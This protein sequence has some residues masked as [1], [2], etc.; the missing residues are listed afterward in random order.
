MN[1][2]V[3]KDKIEHY[4][5]VSR[6]AV[7]VIKQ[8]GFDEIREE[9]AKDFLNMAESYLS[10]AQH[11]FEKGDYV[12]AYGALNYAHAWLDAGARI[13]LFKVSDSKLFTV[14][15]EQAL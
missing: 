13:R 10:D 11:F 8:S 1:D 6:K 14:D 5:S 4:F 12:L 7:E 9:E 3:T 15:E 2:K